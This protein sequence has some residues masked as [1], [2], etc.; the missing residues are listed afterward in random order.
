MLSRREDEG[1]LCRKRHQ[2]CSCLAATGVTCNHGDLFSKAKY[3][4]SPTSTR[5]PHMSCHHHSWEEEQGTGG[6]ACLGI[7]VLLGI[8][9]VRSWTCCAVTWCNMNRQFMKQNGE[10]Y[11]HTDTFKYTLNKQIKPNR[12]IL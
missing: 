12:K 10:V 8:P 7:L 1:N 3:H 6:A 11:N 9:A 5:A 2:S 4:P